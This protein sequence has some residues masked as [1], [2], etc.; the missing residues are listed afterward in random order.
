MCSK[1]YSIVS[2]ARQAVLAQPVE[3]ILGKDE[4]GSSILLDSF[5]NPLITQRIFFISILCLSLFCACHCL[6][7]TARLSRTAC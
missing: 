2:L 4:V 5:K 6:A 3:R 7:S 1:W